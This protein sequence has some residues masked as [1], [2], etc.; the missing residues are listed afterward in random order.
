MSRITRFRAWDK[1]SKKMWFPTA[2]SAD[3]RNIALVNQFGVEAEDRQKD[4]IMQYTGLKD[5]NGKKIYEGDIVEWVEDYLGEGNILKYKSEVS[6]G[7]GS[8]IISGS[9]LS[10]FY[11]DEN[12]P[13]EVIGN[14]YKNPELL[15]NN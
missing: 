9:P 5:K 3:G 14:I 1:K 7:G 4:S 6:F 2:I 8:F 15:T 12:S 11:K 13:F 10:E